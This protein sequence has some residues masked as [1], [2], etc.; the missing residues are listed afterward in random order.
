V[1]RALIAAGCFTVVLVLLASCTGRGRSAAFHPG[2]PAQPLVSGALNAGPQVLQP[3]PTGPSAKA[4][5]A[6]QLS[7]GQAGGST[8]SAGLVVVVIRL[9]NKSSTR[10]AVQG[11]P[12]FTLI[13]H[14]QALGS[15][16]QEEINVQPGGLTELAAFTHLP[17][18]VV[19]SGG[20]H[21]GFLLGY[22]DKPQNGME[23]CPQATKM[24]LTLPTGVTPVS[25]SVKVTV[26]GQPIR[27]SPFV[28]SAEL[29][30][31]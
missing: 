29:T 8:R 16:I 9:T 17:G 19:L 15:D 13:A 3:S 1:R 24:S 7:L 2:E 5:N 18:P 12:S 31:R 30:L 23:G 20:E 28:E 10:C 26:C 6:S 27:I 14:S 25:G 11:Y 22:S 21:G 4:C